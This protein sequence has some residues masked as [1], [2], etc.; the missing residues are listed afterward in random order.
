[1]N[2]PG[3]PV[4]IDQE[5]GVLLDAVGSGDRARQNPAFTAL[6]QATRA[7][8]PWAYDIWD[9]LVALL[10][11]RNNRTRAIAAQVL[12]NLAKSDPEEH[13]IRDL[14]AL[15]EVT[16]DARFVTARHCMQSL[17]KVGV[18]GAEPRAHLLRGLEIRFR[19]CMDE[20]NGTLTR[21]DILE[22]MRRVYDETGDPVYRSQAQ[23]WIEMEGDPRYRAKYER[24]WR[25]A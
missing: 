24:L 15:L 18:A 2:G 8:V 10:S 19:E 12:C 1:M 20:K 11:H 23:A 9:E 16:R 22:C 6:M 3:E 4:P 5:L 13:M 17:W 25:G 7:P 14:D 21:F